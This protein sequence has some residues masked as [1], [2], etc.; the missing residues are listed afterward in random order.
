ME[1][2]R[3]GLPPFGL[4][5]PNDVKDWVKEQSFKDRMSMNSWILRLIERKKEQEGAQQ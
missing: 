2:G 4:R 1:P 3:R 5:M